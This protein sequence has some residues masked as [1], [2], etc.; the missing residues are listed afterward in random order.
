MQADVSVLKTTLVVWNSGFCNVNSLRSLQSAHDDRNMA[1]ML[2]PEERREKK[3]KKLFDDT[4]IDSM[5][6]VYKVSR[7]C[8]GLYTCT[9]M[10]G[11][12]SLSA[13]F[14]DTEIDFMVR[15]YK[16]HQRGLHG[17]ADA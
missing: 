17:I 4:E 2:T 10:R 1:R 12:G 7:D 9:C 14:D 11:L 3:S 6:S 16:V 15:V 13:L 8:T 5:G